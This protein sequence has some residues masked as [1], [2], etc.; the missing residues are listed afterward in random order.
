[1]DGMRKAPPAH[2]HTHTPTYTPTPPTYPPPNHE[3]TRIHT[4]AP[5]T[6][7]WLAPRRPGGCQPPPAPARSRL[8]RATARARLRVMNTR[9]AH[10]RS[11]KRERNAERHLWCA[12]PCT[13]APTVCRSAPL[14]LGRQHVPVVQP[15]Y[16][17]RVVRGND[18]AQR[19][20]H[21]VLVP[22]AVDDEALELCSSHKQ[23][24]MNQHMNTCEGGSRL[25]KIPAC[26]QAQHPGTG[27]NTVIRPP[28]YPRT[29]APSCA[30]G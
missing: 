12:H 23:A 18:G 7:S 27:L 29:H 30:R 4:R 25:L 11:V 24:Q 2:P 10:T 16:G 9:I 22:D 26:T 21:V 8:R 19:P 13:Q 1:M 6:P 20:S 3:G 14:T 15:R 17:L 28:T 5:C